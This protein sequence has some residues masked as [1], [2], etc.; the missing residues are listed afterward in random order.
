MKSVSVFDAK[1]HFSNLIDQVY[2]QGETIIITRRGVQVARLVP[3]GEQ[4]K[5]SLSSVFHELDMLGNEVGKTGIGLKEI[6]KMKDEG[7]L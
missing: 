5:Q 3:F 4:H 6:K 2:E 7:R 1:T